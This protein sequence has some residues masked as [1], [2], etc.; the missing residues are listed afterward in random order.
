MALYE[1]PLIN[2]LADLMRKAE[3]RQRFNR[4]QMGVLK[5]YGLDATGDDQLAVFL[6]MD[7]PTIAA[8][9]QALFML[10]EQR[11][12]E[13]PRPAR[14]STSKTA[15]RT[16]CIPRRPPVSSGSSPAE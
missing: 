8:K 4:D 9:L 2:L 6:T 13:F 10:A 11:P 7:K 14:T 1:I 5:E 12:G 15:D 16:P 3:L